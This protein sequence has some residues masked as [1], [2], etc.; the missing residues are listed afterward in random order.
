MKEKIWIYK[1][2]GRSV[3]SY[4]DE[5]YKQYIS[6]GDYTYNKYKNTDYIISIDVAKSNEDIKIEKRQERIDQLLNS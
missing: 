4:S 6:Y 2:K 5:D 3:Y 1:N